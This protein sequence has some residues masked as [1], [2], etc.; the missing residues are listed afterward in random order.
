MI[1]QP[2]LTLGALALSL[3][4]LLVAPPGNEPKMTRPVDLAW[5]NGQPPPAGAKVA[6]MQ[7]GMSEPLAFTVRAHG[8]NSSRKQ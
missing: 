6:A 8:G 7:G 3:A 5:S 2:Y 4:L 1:M